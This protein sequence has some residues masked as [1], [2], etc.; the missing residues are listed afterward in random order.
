M[1]KGSRG[2]GGCSVSRM[3]I[4]SRISWSAFQGA[5]GGCSWGRADELRG[6]GCGDGDEGVRGD[7]LAEWF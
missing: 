1:P 4:L 7:V 2:R 3:T 6:E 5:A